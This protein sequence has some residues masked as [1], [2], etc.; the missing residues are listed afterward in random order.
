MTLKLETLVNYDAVQRLREPAAWAL[1]TAAGLQ[2]LAGLILLFAASSFTVQAVSEVSGGNVLTGIALAAIVVVAVLLVT[3]GESPS[4]QARTIVLA[5]LVIL[6]LA[7]LFTVV[8]VLA[9]LAAGGDETGLGLSSK[10]AVFLY[11]VAKVIVIGIAAYFVYTVFQALQPARPAAQPGGIPQGQEGYPGY[12]QQGQYGDYAQPQSYEQQGYA[13][14]GYE[15][16][17]YE[18]QGYQQ[19]PGYGQQYQQ[20]NQPDYQQQQQQ[21]YGQQQ[22]DY[23]QQQTDPV[24]QPYGQ[25]PQPGYGQEPQPGYGQEPEQGYGQEQQQQQQGYGQQPPAAG[26]GDPGLWTRSY[27]SDDPLQSGYPQ[28][29]EEKD[30]NW[31]RDDRHS[32]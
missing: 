30:Q 24:Q 17:G 14:Q 25:Q 18:Q 8:A 16:Q 23:Y 20:Y 31:Y 1:I 2:L 13:P 19:Q 10:L 12:P 28:S 15:Q 27:G 29:G 21:P 5:G 11:G 26:E 7:A 6:G 9:G 32:Q 22:P 4:P 3:R